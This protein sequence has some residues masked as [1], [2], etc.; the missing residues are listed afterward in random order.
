MLMVRWAGGNANRCRVSEIEHK[1]GSGL[2]EEVV[3]VARGELDLV[4]Q[5]K[6]A[7]V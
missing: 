6:D 1:I 2:I 7:Q 5:M 4:N 3:N